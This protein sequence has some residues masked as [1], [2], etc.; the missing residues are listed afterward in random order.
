MHFIPNLA[1]FF[2]SDSI[3]WPQLE[4]DLTI[5]PCQSALLLALSLQLVSEWERDTIRGVVYS[6]RTKST[7]SFRVETGPYTCSCEKTQ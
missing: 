3:C 5:P 2:N 7:V 6:T 4:E 1:R